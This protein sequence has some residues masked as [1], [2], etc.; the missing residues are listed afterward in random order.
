MSHGP[1]KSIRSGKR[2]P[3]HVHPR[4]LAQ[5]GRPRHQ[6]RQLAGVAPGKV[7]ALEDGVRPQHRTLPPSHAE[8]ERRLGTLCGVVVL[9]LGGGSGQHAVGRLL[10]S[11]EVDGGQRVAAEH[12]AEDRLHFGA[13]GGPAGKGDVLR[14][15]GVELGAH[16]VLAKGDEDVVAL[17]V[18]HHHLVRVVQWV[19]AGCE[20][21]I[22]GG[23]PLACRRWIP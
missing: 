6:L 12:A 11:V 20:T 3:P 2:H 13:A 23:G 4:H 22:P 18:L 5:V 19:W 15:A 8:V 9:A 14:G 1:S 10:R 17:Q 16:E 7:V 21:S